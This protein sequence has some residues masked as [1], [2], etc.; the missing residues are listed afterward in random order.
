MELE[1]KI[2][3]WLEKQ[4]YPLEMFATQKFKQQGFFVSQSLYYHDDELEK[5]REIDVIAHKVKF[6]EDSF[7]TIDY[8]IECKSSHKPW[9]L[10]TNKRNQKD[11]SVNELERYLYSKDAFPL[12]LNLSTENKLKHLTP[13]YF[14]FE[15]IGYG[16][17]QAFSNG[18]DMAYKAITALTKCSLS[19]IKESET[20]VYQDR[21]LIIPILVVDSPL[22]EVYLSTNYEMK[23][24]KKE[25]AYLFI[26]NLIPD[27]QQISIMILTKDYL[28]QFA[29][30]A[31]KSVDWLFNYCVN[32]LTT[33]LAEYQ[34]IIKDISPDN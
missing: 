21:K 17:T 3:N 2:S 27:Y 31:N 19:L 11:D 32:N 18:N 12:L 29:I 1:I 4:G 16:L 7:I 20:K 22:F 9:L 28:E 23:I 25:I 5:N 10:F 6:V 26:K 14:G 30:S 24:V 33:I 13:Y 34:D 8:I 15:N